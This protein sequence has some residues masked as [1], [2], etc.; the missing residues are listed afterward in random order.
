[1]DAFSSGWCFFNL[2]I[3]IEHP[4][5]N[6]RIIKSSCKRSSE[7]P[8]LQTHGY[9]VTNA[10]TIIEQAKSPR[11]SADC[12]PGSGLSRRQLDFGMWGPFPAMRMPCQLI[13]M[14]DEALRL[15]I[16]RSWQKHGLLR[17][18]EAPFA[19][20][21][22]PVHPWLGKESFQQRRDEI[23]A[24]PVTSIEAQHPQFWEY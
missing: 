1:M 11:G 9:L 12:W 19:R 22:C 5:R 3:R 23:D 6:E 10:S 21:P 14:Q 18:G 24:S 15:L 16:T 8:S 20:S 13:R 17:S 2:P 7:C 4:P